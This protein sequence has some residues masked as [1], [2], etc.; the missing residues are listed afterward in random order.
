MKLLQIISLTLL[1]LFSSTLS[2]FG[3]NKEKN[4]DKGRI[5][6][7]TFNIYHGETYYKNDKD[8]DDCNINIIAH[9]IDSLQPDLVALQEVDFKTNRANGKDLVTELGF[10]T[11]MSPLFGKAMKYDGGEYGVGIL[12]RHSFVKTEKHSLVYGKDKEPRSAL[13]VIIE[14]PCGNPIRFIGTH[15]DHTS[16]DIRLQQ[17]RQLNEFFASDNIPSILAGDLNAEPNSET[18]QTLFKK[19]NPSSPLNK[20]TI[21]S[22]NPKAKIDYI[23]F[24]PANTWKVIESKVIDEKKAS[25]HNP[26]FSIIELA[27]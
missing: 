14:L 8:S 22:I 9:I 25:D 15:L 7:L 1:I 26:V 5:K 18:M 12:S 19:W 21:P 11:K 16:K 24:R 17:V 27:I 23:L 13:S 2:I 6:V 4:S 10:K 3:K 20:P